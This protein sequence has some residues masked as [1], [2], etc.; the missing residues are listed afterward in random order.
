MTEAEVVEAKPNKPKLE[1]SNE[2]S[3]LLQEFLSEAEAFL[4]NDEKEE[5]STDFNEYSV[6]TEER[7]VK[8]LS[9][10]ETCETIV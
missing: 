8:Q 5:K 3:I 1:I 7:S 9:I 10:F 6:N 4:N 2:L